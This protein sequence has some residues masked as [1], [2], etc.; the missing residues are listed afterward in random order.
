MADNKK[1]A[2]GVC[3]ARLGEMRNTAVSIAKTQKTRSFEMDAAAH[4]L[5]PKLA[6]R[7]HANPG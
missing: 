5:V 4:P 6:R 2:H 3:D 7:W 1:C